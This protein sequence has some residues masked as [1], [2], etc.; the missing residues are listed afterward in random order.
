[1][2][3]DFYTDPLPSG[4]DLVW[5]SAIIHQN[6]PTQNRQLYAR[7][8]Q[9][10]QPGGWVYIRDIV[11]DESRTAPVAGAMFAVNMLTA[12]KS[13]NS[14]TLEEMESDLTGAGFTHVELVRRDE[15]MHSVV[16]AQLA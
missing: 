1:M 16:R 4:A 9:A 6:S 3:G 8:A 11:L 10:I 2:A 5:V 14:Y 7:I 13:G 15:G 12:T